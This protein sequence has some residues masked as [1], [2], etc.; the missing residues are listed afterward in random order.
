MCGWVGWAPHQGMVLT[1]G[2]NG[3]EEHPACSPER[4]VSYPKSHKEALGPSWSSKMFRKP[5]LKHAPPSV[6]LPTVPEETDPFFYGEC[7]VLC[8]GD[9]PRARMEGY[10][11]LGQQTWATGH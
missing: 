8:W 7:W 1:D 2:L 6:F 5:P 10:L 11:Q 4:S 9:L 3:S